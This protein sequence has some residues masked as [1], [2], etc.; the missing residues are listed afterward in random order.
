M[1]ES[2]HTRRLPIG[3]E[4]VED[5]LHYRLWAPHQRRL[6]LRVEGRPPHPLT[7]DAQ[8][9]Y[10]GFVSDVRAGD[11]YSL[12]LDDGHVIPDPVS[13][14]Q[15]EG[16]HGP[17]QLID[18]RPFRWT[19]SAWRGRPLEEQVLYEMHVGTFTRDGTW[20]SALLQLDE[21]ASLGITT[22]E[23]MPV[24][25]FPGNWGWGYDGVCLFA[26]WHHYGTPDD[27]RG[28][29][30]KAHRVGIGIVLDV[31]YNHLGPDGNYLARLSPNYF[32]TAHQTDWG[33]AINFDGP[34][35]GPVREFFLTNARYWI[36]EF[37]LDGLRL[38]A[39]QDIHDESPRDRHIL[40]EIGQTARAAASDRTIVLIAE[41]EPQHSELCRSIDQGGS[42]LD[43]L[44]NDDFHHSAMVA[45][46]GRRE[47]YYTDYLGEPQEFINAAKYGYLYQGQWY[48]WQKKRRGHPG[49]D[50]TPAAFIT[51]LQNHDQIA[52][53]FSGLRAHQLGSPGR[54]RALT[55]LL[56]LGP[57]TPMLFQGQEFAAS[58]PFLYFADHNPELARLV[59]EGRRNFLTQFPSLNNSEA[60]EKLHDPGD[61]STYRDCCLNFAERDEHAPLYQLTRDLLAL[62]KVEPCFRQ[63]HR[64]G[65]DGAVL[66]PEAFLLRYFLDDDGDR[67]LLVNLGRELRL[68]TIPQPLLGCVDDQAWQVLVSTENPAYGG[69]G[70]GPLETD[71]GWQIPAESALFLGLAPLSTQG[72]ES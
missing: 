57:G 5:G 64:R 54:Y 35:S 19:D 26:P 29:V 10:S 51:F 21:L 37:H 30:D 2:S 55:A 22:L 18:S 72:V 65:L 62:R 20:K 28:F 42:G 60:L 48:S 36:E 39:T 16:A 61:A 17:S 6:G 23:V 7:Q 56:L 53:S 14:F 68:S 43:A 45:L 9:Y 38:D 11:R 27:F 69:S 44:W 71:Q 32:S 50:L 52:N 24:A 15:P 4:L 66:G 33:A 25:E 63:Q 1:T 8:G 40:T 3:P 58:T 67:I 59:A 70:V 13:R 46:T 41:N 34:D 49:L 12:V 31:V 47:A